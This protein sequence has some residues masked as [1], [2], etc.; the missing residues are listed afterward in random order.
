VGR[1]DVGRFREGLPFPLGTGLD[2]WGR[3]AV[4]AVLARFRG[5][6]GGVFSS[7]SDREVRS[8]EESS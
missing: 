4:L 3:L 2:C 5:R 1:E 8:S 7:G 6:F